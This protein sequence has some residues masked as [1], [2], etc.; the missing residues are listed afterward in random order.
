MLDWIQHRGLTQYNMDYYYTCP[1]HTD[2]EKLRNSLQKAINRHDIFFTRVRMEGTEF[3]QYIDRTEDIVVEYYEMSD[4]AFGCF[5][6]CHIKPF[7]LLNDVLTRAAVVRTE[8]HVYVIIDISHLLSDALSTALLWEDVRCEYEGREAPAEDIPYARSVEKERRL[9]LSE[10]YTQAAD[11]YRKEF[12]GLTMTKIPTRHPEAVGSFKG[13]VRNMPKDG[14]EAF[15]RARGVTP[16]IMLMTAFAMALSAFSNEQNVVFYS[17]NH[18]RTDRE[19]KKT[20]GMFVKTV[21]FKGDL[22]DPEKPVLALMGDFRRQ[23]AGNV[24]HGLYPFTH[25]CRDLHCLPENSFNFHAVHRNVMLGGEPVQTRQ[26]FSGG[27]LDS[28]STQI[29]DMDDAYQLTIDYNDRRYSQWLMEQLAAVFCDIVH[30]IL[31]KPDARLCDI[32]FVSEEKARALLQLGQ[33]TPLPP[34]ER[35]EHHFLDM[36]L[37]QVALRPQA[38][39]IVDHEGSMTYAE[40]DRQS[41]LLA[42]QLTGQGQVGPDD[43]VTVM[44]PRNRDFMTAVL[45]VMKAGACYVPLA[46]DYPA[47]RI[48]YIQADSE[49]RLHIDK[50]YIDGFRMQPLPADIPAARAVGANAYIIYTS[51]STGKPKGVTISHRALCS[52]VRTCI[53]TYGLTPADKILCHGT[54]SFDASVEDLFPILACGGELHI[55]REEDRT[56]L[57]AIH[58]YIVEH[59]ITGGNYTTAFGELL[60]TAYPDLPLRYVTLGGERLDQVPEG[61]ACRFF[62][63]YG[64]TEFTVDATFWEY[65]VG[66]DRHYVPIG[67]PVSDC[68]A[69]VLDSRQRILPQ[70]C[71]GELY[72]AGPQIAEGYL[73]N[74]G[75][76]ALKF[77]PNP[78]ATGD[79]DRRMFR[80]GDIVQWDANGQLMFM[81]RNDTQVK[82]RGY[83]IELGEIEALMVQTESIQKAVTRVITLNGRDVMCAW[84]VA[85]RPVSADKLK[86]QL[87]RLIPHYMIP[88]LFMQV[89]ELPVNA[90]GKVDRH[91]LPMPLTA[92]FSPPNSFVPPATDREHILSSLTAQII[93]SGQELSVADDLFDDLGLSSL[94]AAQLAFMASSH[95]INISVTTLYEKRTIR[96]L[97]ADSAERR[98]SYWVDGAYDSSKPVM[99]IVCGY[100]YLHPMYDELVAWFRTRCSVYVIDSFL[101]SFMWKEEITLEKLL[102]EYMLIYRHDLQGKPIRFFTGLCYGSDIALALAKRIK[103]DLGVAEHVLTFDPIYERSAIQET[104]PVEMNCGPTIIEQY[105]VSNALALTVPRP[106]YDGPVIHLF[107][108]VHTNRKY[109]EYDDVFLNDEEQQA[110]DAFVAQNEERWRKHF[111]DVPLYHIDGDHFHYMNLANMPHIEAIINKHWSK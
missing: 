109:P 44:L 4:A 56:D 8:K 82:L 99:V 23:M 45:A 2:A 18:G 105:R 42:R 81:G 101:E 46:T 62:N 90:N 67:R 39:A 31:S 14:V 61:L 50:Q 84:F 103:H 92:H 107:A 75:M 87:A 41:S 78:Y 64:P 17:I 53:F 77:M 48:A 29:W 16:N 91:R 59:A 33:G 34:A 111:P 32:D 25:F 1:A 70:G 57:K 43:V 73:N 79:A 51:G 7:N 110:Q 49:A 20:L 83:R 98:H 71:P 106:S 47:D 88:E 26:F 37:R 35:H 21:P 108:A 66:S 54:F 5:R 12:Q 72:L 104:P 65:P 30:E 63:S 11:Y 68:I 15:C 13:I 94:Q 55:L 6:D 36:F 95:G 74:P 85:P 52:F 76:T 89:D 102:D 3:R 40:L 97:C 69:L 10:A 22:S 19:A 58:D 38:T 80:T 28:I 60:L 96:E 86:N 9:L 27:T 100:V 93:E 24:R